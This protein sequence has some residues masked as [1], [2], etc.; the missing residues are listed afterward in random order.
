MFERFVQ[1][2]V[3]T[4]RSL[5]LCSL[6]AALGCSAE[7][8]EPPGASQKGPESPETQERCVSTRQFFLQQVWPKVMAQKCMN[9]H[10]P[11]GLAASRS[12]SLIL[13]PTSYPGFVEQNLSSLKEL[14]KTEYEDKSV[15]LRKPMGEL[16]HG[17]GVQITEDGEEAALLT[18]LVGRLQQEETCVAGSA[19]PAVSGVELA[20]PAATFRK[21]SL[22]L[23]GRL[24]TPEETHALEGPGGE[25]AL[26]GLVDGLLEEPAFRDWLL[27][28]FNDLFLTDRYLRD[29]T[30]TLRR[31]DFPNVD[32]Y[33]GDDVPDEEKRKYRRSVAR[34]PL[35][36][37]A[38]IV[39]NNRPFTE[40]LTADYTVH[41]PYSA[42]IYNDSTIVFQ[43]PTDENDYQPGTIS[44]VRQGEV[45][46]FP[47]AGILS[48]PMFLNRFPTSPTNRNRHRARIIFEKFLA[49]DILKIGDRPIDPTQS[50]AFANPTREDPSCSVCHSI[51]DPVAGAFMK[52]SDSDAE[53]LLPARE[54]YKEMFLPGF[55]DEAMQVSDYPRALPWVAERIARDPRFPLSVVLNVYRA[56]TGQTPLAYPSDGEPSQLSSWQRQ[57]ATFRSIAEAF[58]AADYNYKV[59][60]REVVLSPYFRAVNATPETVSAHAGELE[61]YGTARLSTPEN[62]AKKLRAIVGFDW[63]RYDRQP[64]VTT[65]YN[66]LY[67]GIDSELVT[68]RLEEPNGVM[69]SVM[70]RMANEVACQAAAWDFLKPADQRLLFPLVE[71]TDTPANGAER[72]RANLRHL[73]ARVLGEVLADDSPELERTFALFRDTW[74]EGSEKV[75]SKAIG[76]S[77]P[78]S[79]RGRWNRLTGEEL[80]EGERLEEDREYTIRSW[81][82][83]LTYLLTD[84]RFLYE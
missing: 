63:V 43:D 57:D 58:V 6:V 37:I 77:L 60:V 3:S 64:H 31:E 45:L 68:Q 30:N 69:S 38:Y 49:T 29:S 82:A 67:G 1:A 74:Q 9:C 70:S 24:P 73:H 66:I 54:W 4:R 11:G 65:T 59:V 78:W 32:V 55:G 2:F 56:L 21:A 39:R 50:V 44:A 18:E 25:E 20:S 33:V 19:P 8:R 23:A 79:C 41:N 13:Y 51:I 81:M 34:E 5:S 16:R 27:V 46:P 42:R 10:A 80:P 17:G 72:I 76:R 28:T 40:I 84:Y 61:P 48:S 7:V 36:L 15:L 35:E 75:E 26:P 12:A 52:F 47:H 53:Q 71:V 62:L 83:V 14:A 22:I